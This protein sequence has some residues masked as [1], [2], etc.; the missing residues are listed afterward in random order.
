LAYYNYYWQDSIKEAQIDM[1]YY[2]SV[3]YV[4]Q[5]LYK[6]SMPRILQMGE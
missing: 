5:M 1:F 2:P 3:I 6:L 4:V